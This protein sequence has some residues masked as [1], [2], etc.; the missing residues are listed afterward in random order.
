MR[1]KIR[2]ALLLL[3]DCS[4]PICSHPGTRAC[5]LRTSPSCCAVGRSI[6]SDGGR[7][8]S[9]CRYDSCAGQRLLVRALNE[10]SKDP[11]VDEAYLHVQASR[12]QEPS[13]CR[14][15]SSLP[16]SSRSRASGR[17]HLIWLAARAGTPAPA[18]EQHGGD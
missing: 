1:G 2:A 7:V 6:A 17:P 5:S 14:V 16:V 13:P 3:P 11:N 8:P 12:L 10:A 4:E 15:L 9:A 18:D